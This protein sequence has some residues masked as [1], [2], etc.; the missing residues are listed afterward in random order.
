MFTLL[1]VQAG[2]FTVNTA[3]PRTVPITNVAAANVLLDA[4]GNQW[5]QQQDNF[6]FVTIAVTYPHCYC[7]GE[8]Q[9]RLAVQYRDETVGAWAGIPGWGGNGRLPIYSE[10]VEI[11]AENFF[12]WN[13]MAI[14]A[15][16][17]VNFAISLTEPSFDVSMAN[18]PAGHNAVVMPV[19]VTV[20]VEHNLETQ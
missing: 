16:D 2:Q 9:G 1:F 20:K 4:D 18:V 14:T 17:R 10:N 11:E 15:G 8:L 6:R 3:G 13:E 12:R 7:A 19:F 5:F